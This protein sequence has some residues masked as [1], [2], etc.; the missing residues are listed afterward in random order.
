MAKTALITGA[1]SGI[2]REFAVVFAEHGHNLIL[3]ARNKIRLMELKQSLEKKHGVS[4]HVFESD[5]ATPDVPREIFEK[6]VRLGLSVDILVNNAGLGAYG[7]F[8]ETDWDREAS[9]LAVNV[10]ALTNL[11]KLFLP[12]ML[13]GKS[14]AILN[15]ASAAA[16]Q[17]GPYMAVYYATKAY[18]LSFSEALAEE[19]CGTGVSVTI[20]CPGPTISGFFDTAKMH[21]SRLVKGKKLPTARTVAHFG[22]RALQQKKVIAVHGIKV[23]LLTS[24]VRFMPRAAVRKIVRTMQQKYRSKK[25]S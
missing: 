6:T 16:F 3:V 4:V 22:Y 11:T 1:S 23:K 9:V 19:L 21:D 20:L 18:V 12:Q 5:L 14:G 15:V 2:G 25:E 8:A 7:R 13:A 10:H 24:L 17:P